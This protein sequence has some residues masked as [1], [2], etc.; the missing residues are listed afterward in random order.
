MEHSLKVIIDGIPIVDCEDTDTEGV[1]GAL[2]ALA[3]TATCIRANGLKATLIVL[4]KSLGLQHAIMR[5]ATNGDAFL[6][7]VVGLPT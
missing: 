7:T 1:A 6:S 5:E 2:E 3:L 4:C